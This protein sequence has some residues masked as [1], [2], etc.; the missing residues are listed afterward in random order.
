MM[1]ILLLT[2][3]HGEEFT[4]E[5][6]ALKCKLVQTPTRIVLVLGAP[7]Q[8]HR[9]LLLQKTQFPRSTYYNASPTN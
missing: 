3:L 9:D 8:L 6:P 1:V 5:P 2:Y 7:F 4:V